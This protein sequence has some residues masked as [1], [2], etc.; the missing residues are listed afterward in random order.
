MYQGQGAGGNGA[1][2]QPSVLQPSGVSMAMAQ[3]RYVPPT[4]GIVQIPNGVP[5]TEQ[6]P[7]PNGRVPTGQGVMTMGHSQM[8]L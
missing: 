4:A 6:A 7:I 2:T 8:G 3:P 5:K 1:P